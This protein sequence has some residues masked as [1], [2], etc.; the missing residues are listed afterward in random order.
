MHL[1]LGMNQALDISIELGEPSGVNTA[2]SQLDRQA[3]EELVHRYCYYFDRNQPEELSKL[4]ADDAEVD[5]GPEVANLIG[6]AQIYQMVS[7]GLAETFAAT[8]HHISNFIVTFQSDSSATSNS[9]LYAW[10]KYYSKEEIGHLW[11]GYE[12]EFVKIDGKWFI[13]KLKLFGVGTQGFHRTNMHS[14]GRKP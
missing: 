7:K 8:S 5:Y 2:N 11:G 9:Y 4:F 14:N 12:H 13:K 10:H 3:V 1:E 6:R